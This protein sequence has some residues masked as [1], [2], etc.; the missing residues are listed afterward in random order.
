M[1]INLLEAIDIEEDGEWFGSF[2]EADQ[3]DWYQREKW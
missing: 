1:K 2:G 3:Q